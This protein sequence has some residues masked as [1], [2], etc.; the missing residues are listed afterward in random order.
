MELTSDIDEL[1]NINT[2]ENSINDNW[3]ENY[4]REE[5]TFNRFYKKKV[6]KINTFFIYVDKNKNI[7]KCLKNILPIKDSVLLKNDILPI[8]NKNKHLLKKHFKLIKILQYNFDI[9]NITINKFLYDED[10]TDYLKVMDKIK[11]I[12]WLDTIP[13]FEKLNSLY[14][15]FFEKSSHHTKKI[16]LKRK[17]RAKTKKRKISE[18]KVQK[19]DIIKIE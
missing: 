11:D 12:Y 4:L 14:F 7:I 5:K 17:K 3:L 16:F 6:E 10:P 8:I 13:L 18:M 2:M 9:E 1:N 19:S 15:I